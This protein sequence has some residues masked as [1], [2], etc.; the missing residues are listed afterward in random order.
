MTLARRRAQPTAAYIARLTGTAVFAYLVAQFLPVTSQP[1]LAPLTALLVVQVTMYQTVRSAVRRVASVIAGVLVAVALSAFAGFS[2]W[3]LAIVITAGLAIG[4][5]LH[6]GDQILEVPISAMLILSLSVGTG[7][8]ATTRVAESAIGAAAGL[9]GGLIVT[10]VRVQPAGEA[11]GELSDQLASLLE[12]MAADLDSPSCLRTAN[13]RLAESRSL[14][15]EIQRVNQALAQT[16]D[17]LRLN[18]RGRLLRHAGA[19]LRDGLDALEHASVVVR[20]IARSM[21]DGL[22]GDA[23][24]LTPDAA[25]R[26]VLASLI[27][28]LASAGRS[29]GQLIQADIVSEDEGAG[30][31]QQIEA[32]LQSELQEATRLQDQLADLLN[33]K[34]RAGQSSQQLEAELLAHLDRLRDELDVERRARAR[35][36]WP[37][38]DTKQRRTPAQASRPQAAREAPSGRGVVKLPESGH[39]SAHRDPGNGEGKS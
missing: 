30:Q 11:I 27:R 35:E 33:F 2:L 7:A 29:F 32:G 37:H 38:R 31:R 23:G 25:T 36:R 3:T 34:P 24:G 16:E 14:G 18:P 12:R 15:S 1:V 6:L 10:P 8:A 5:L 28:Q 4:Y 21:A 39:Q 26:H 22:R 9:L 19:A 13:D 17:S 20:G